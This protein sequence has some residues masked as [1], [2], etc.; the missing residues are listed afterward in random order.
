VQRAGS[1]REPELSR[2]LA[3]DQDD[4]VLGAGKLRRIAALLRG[5]LQLEERCADRV[6]QLAQIVSRRGEEIDEKGVVLRGDRTCVERQG[7]LGKI[8]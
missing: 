5:E 3:V 1:C 8:P 4:A 2:A 6:L 7:R